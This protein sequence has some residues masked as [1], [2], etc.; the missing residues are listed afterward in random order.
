MISTPE[1]LWNNHTFHVLLA[2]LWKAR[3][4]AGLGPVRLKVLLDYIGAA[5][6]AV[7]A[8]QP[9]VVPAADDLT[10]R[11]AALAKEAEE[12]ACLEAESVALMGT[13]TVTAEEAA[14]EVLEPKA[15]PKD[16][17]PKPLTVKEKQTWGGYLDARRA[18]RKEPLA[19]LR[20]TAKTVAAK[21][22]AGERV[23][24]LPRSAQTAGLEAIL[25]AE[26]REA[27]F[28]SL[29]ISLPPKKQQIDKLTPGSAGEQT[30]GW[31]I[32]VE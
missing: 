19:A 15:A 32:T 31:L 18:E 5:Q 14:E 9:K 7:P 20:A 27:A 29:S 11:K 24:R 8:A 13:E 23:I 21:I 2:D 6:A 12:L 28:T 26:F 3:K 25:K 17:K 10:L 22:V 16:E 30:S 4:D 1:A